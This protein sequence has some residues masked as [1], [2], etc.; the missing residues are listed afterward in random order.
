MKKSKELKP[1]PELYSETISKYELE[2]RVTLYSLIGVGI[3]NEASER[4]QK[5][6]KAAEILNSLENGK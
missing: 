5:G 1:I 4:K 2:Q 6:D 3:K